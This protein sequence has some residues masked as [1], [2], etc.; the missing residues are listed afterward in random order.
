[1]LARLRT[2]GAL[3]KADATAQCKL[4]KVEV[5]VPVLEAAGKPAVSGAAAL[6]AES[7][8]AELDASYE[9]PA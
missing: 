9:A 2:G 4:S 6:A 5:T 7:D 3:F 1:M 8:H